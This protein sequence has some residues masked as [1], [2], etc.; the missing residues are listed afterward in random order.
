MGAQLTLLKSVQKEID[1]GN[2]SSKGI[3]INPLLIDGKTL[4]LPTDD[5]I[6]WE[7]HNTGTVVCFLW[8]TLELKPSDSYVFPNYSH[9]TI[10]NKVPIWPQEILLT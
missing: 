4:Q 2:G 7:V 5:C 3:T 1:N 6:N 9:Q 8:G 10:L